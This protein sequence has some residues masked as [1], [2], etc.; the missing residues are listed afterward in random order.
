MSSRS[1]WKKKGGKKKKEKKRGVQ[2]WRRTLAFAS[3]WTTITRCPSKRGRKKKRKEV[4]A[5]RMWCICPRLILRQQVRKRGGGAP[6]NVPPRRLSRRLRTVD[7][8]GKERRRGR[9]LW[10]YR[11][12]PSAPRQAATSG[13]E[14]RKR[15]GGEKKKEGG[16]KSNHQDDN[17]L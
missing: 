8:G 4:R 10:Q 7:K 5:C 14:D 6:A 13:S 11:I 1:Q 12:Q 2:C 16:E 9:G 15:G 17:S 3:F